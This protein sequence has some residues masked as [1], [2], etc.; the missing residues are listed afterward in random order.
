MN[1]V[2]V[3]VYSTPYCLVVVVVFPKTFLS[4][5]NA[6][7]VLKV[8]EISEASVPFTSTL[9]LSAVKLLLAKYVSVPL[10]LIVAVDDSL[11]AG[12][13]AL[14]DELI[15]FH[16]GSTTSTSFASSVIIPPGIFT[17]DVIVFAIFPLALVLFP[18]GPLS[19]TLFPATAT[20][21]IP[22]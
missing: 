2:S 15:F 17:P 1:P 12:S 16:I 7:A 6:V 9:I 13:I 8:F 10:N 22:L 3:N 20:V 21:I 18:S 11:F 4:S 14:A 5:V 19:N